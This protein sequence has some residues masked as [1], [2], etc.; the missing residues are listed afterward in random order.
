MSRVAKRF[1]RENGMHADSVDFDFQ[2]RRFTAHMEAGLKGERS[3]LLMLP[4]YVDAT[5][6]PPRGRSAI[7]IDAGGT[8]LRVALVRFDGAG[9]AE[10]FGQK[11][12]PMPGSQGEITAEAFFAELAGHIAP[13]LGESDSLGFGFSFPSEIL[14]NRD[15]RILAFCKEVR[16]SGAEG[17]ELG[18]SLN[19]ALR[20]L[21][22]GE[23]R[24]T[25]VNDTLAGMLGDIATGAVCG[26]SNYVGLIYGTGMNI[27]YCERTENIKKL[28]LTAPPSMVVNTE[29]GIYTGFIR[30][31]CDRALDASTE[32]PGDHQFEK[33]VS[34]A[35]LG[36]LFR[37]C[38]RLAAEQG[39]FDPATAENIRA[40]ES[41]ESFE[42]DRLLENSP[43]SRLA[44]LCATAEAAEA[45]KA[46]CE[47]L[48][49][50]AA[51]LMAVALFAVIRKCGGGTQA[52]PVCIL[53]E[54]S[55][56]YKANRFKERLEGF[57]GPKCAEAGMYYVFAKSDVPNLVGAA[58]AAW[59]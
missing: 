33:M 40:L 9:Q 16:V 8:N 24:I 26:Y 36:P 17:M 30:C 10:I 50:R 21:G 58:A 38:L 37:E 56:F 15:G 7:A 29:S 23:L 18:C 12:V 46:L 11:K 41:L 35:Y 42:L 57:L 45:M 43:G 5:A 55:T 22:H 48:Y 3:S 1:L 34:G 14:P 6:T 28:G 47:G 25:V 39:L 51:K 2:V 32:N 49:D 53:A 54:G 44:S 52:A 59:M 19:R 27:C 4:T 31:D 20:D 13:L